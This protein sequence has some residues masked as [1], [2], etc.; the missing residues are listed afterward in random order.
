MTAGAIVSLPKLVKHLLTL[1]SRKE[2]RYVLNLQ[3]SQAVWEG[4]YLLS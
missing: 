1:T 2:P 4:I 3:E